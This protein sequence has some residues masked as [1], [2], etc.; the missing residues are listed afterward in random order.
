MPVIIMS[1]FSEQDS[2]ERF[3]GG[4]LSGFVAKPF[5]REALVAKLSPLVANR[6]IP[7]PKA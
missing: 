2:Y 5:D 3:A 7:E 4:D 1:G 6:K